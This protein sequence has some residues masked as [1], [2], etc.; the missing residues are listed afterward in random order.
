[1]LFNVQPL[2]L[3]SFLLRNV[4][5]SVDRQHHSISVGIR[6]GTVI[7]VKDGSNQV[8]RF[9]GIP[10]AQPPVG[11]LRLRQAVPL[12]T[13]FGAFHAESFG[14]ACVGPVIDS[15]PNS[16]EDC[17]TLNIWRPFKHKI[18]DQPKPVLVWFYGG[19]LRRGYT[20]RQCNHMEERS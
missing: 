11:D 1:M 7:G 12:N 20:V 15:N 16:S 4:I 18:V 5:A 17:L 14:P 6:N 10:Y 9:L 8:Q 3:F 13:S 19:G 2:L